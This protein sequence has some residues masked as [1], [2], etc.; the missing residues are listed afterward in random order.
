MKRLTVVFMAVAA[1]MLFAAG[2]AQAGPAVQKATGSIVMSNPK[3]AAKFEVFERSTNKG[4]VTYTNF[5][6]ADASGVFVPNLGTGFTLS[7]TNVSDGVNLYPGPFTHTIT[8]DSYE[9]QS[10]TEITFVGHGSYDDDPAWT[11]SIVGSV[12]GTQV[13][14]SLIPDDGGSKYGWTEA[15]F[16]GT[17]ESDGTM[18][19][20]AGDNYN[21]PTG[22]TYDWAIDAE[23]AHSVFSYK[24]VVDCVNVL[25]AQNA[26]FGY[27][28][29]TGLHA[30]TS[31]AVTVTDNGSS[32]VGHDTWAHTVGS[33][34]AV[35]TD[36]PI[37]AGNLVLHV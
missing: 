33:C 22:R 17:I 7:L 2:A 28:I 6:V 15:A 27:T 14:L 1:F 19:G 8:F 26:N 16:Q 4:S 13:E 3:Q 5:E 31:V 35:G 10:P 11:E 18:S 20:T 9:P 21:A 29:P 25:D 30:G 12:H 37:T 23:A 24:A 34:G 32:G 36:Y